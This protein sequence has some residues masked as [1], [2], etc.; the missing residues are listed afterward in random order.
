M[1][2][3]SPPNHAM[4]SKE[5]S[6]PAYWESRARR[7]ATRGRGLA[8]VCSYGMPAFY[9]HSIEIG[10]RR[11]LLPWLPRVEAGSSTALDV[12]CGVGRWSQELARR[13]H[14]VLGLDLSPTMI[15]QARRQAAGWGT[16]CSFALGDVTTLDLG[17]TFDFIVCVTVLQHVLNPAEARGA[18]ARLASHLAP[19]GTLVLLEAAPTRLTGRCDTAVFRARTVAWYREALQ[20]AGLS[21]CAQAGVDPM[22][23]KIWLLPHY[24]R[25][26]PLLAR[27]A[28]AMA[29]TLAF[30]LDW[31][32]RRW[33]TGLS[34]HKVIIAR[35]ARAN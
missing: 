9:N 30:P 3:V 26:P 15:E 6:A 1:T 25:L 10:Q 4:T 13:G 7:F 29:T 35:R 21:V 24:R 23:F 16:R 19:G 31:A 34:W 8:A 20:A 33:L 17:R 11:A 27:V 14:H 32:L 18:V 5:A 22:P 12:G 28:L 2:V